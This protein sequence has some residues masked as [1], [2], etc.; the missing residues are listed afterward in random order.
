MWAVGCGRIGFEDAALG[1]TGGDGAVG[2]DAGPPVSADAGGVAVDAGDDAQVVVVMDA[3]AGG[4]GVSDA[5]PPCSESPCRLVAPQCG[6]AAAQM[7]QRAMAGS[8][9]RSCVAAGTTTIGGGC[10]FSTECAPATGCVRAGTPTGQCEPWCESSAD[11]GV[12]GECMRLGMGTDVGA[13]S[14]GCDPVG[15]GTTG[16]PPDLVCRVVLGERIPD[17]AATHAAICSGLGGAAAGAACSTSID[18]GPG[19]YCA[20]SVCRHLCG[21]TADCVAPAT[22]VALVPAFRGLGYCM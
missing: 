18:C 3:G 11:C 6:C 14:S 16:C 1:A 2:M 21:A 9:V 10:T 20:G 8:T 13:C 12:S 4:A 7:C 19:L 22:C 15:S 5:G 17:M